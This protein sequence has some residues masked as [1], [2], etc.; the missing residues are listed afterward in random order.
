MDYN[1]NVTRLIQ[2]KRSDAGMTMQKLADQMGLSLAQL[3]DRMAGRKA[4]SVPEMDTAAS[5]FGMMP[6]DF[7]KAAELLP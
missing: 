1:V 2:L 5:A 3:K 7:A 4:W 6:G